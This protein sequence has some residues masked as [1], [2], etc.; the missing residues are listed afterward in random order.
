MEKSATELRNELFEKYFEEKEGMNFSG[1]MKAS[2]PILDVWKKLRPYFEQNVKGFFFHD[3]VEM[4]KEVN[5]RGKNFLIVKF[6]IWKYLIVDLDKKESLQEEEIGNYFDE[7]FFIENFKD[8]KVEK[9][10]NYTDCY[11]FI[12]YL[13]DVSE[14][15]TFYRN[16]KMLF[17]V[18]S[19]IYY[20]IGIENAWTY[21]SVDF[22]SGSV[23]LGFQ[24]ED[25]FLYEQLF[26]NS[27]LEPW[28]MQDAQSKIGKEKMLEMFARIKDIRIP[29][30]SIPED[31][32][33]V[34]SI[35]YEEPSTVQK[36]DSKQKKIGQ[37][38]SG[39]ENK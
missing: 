31:L 10:E 2:Q 20:R 9:R 19:Q 30:S 28:A 15:I 36:G 33:K 18:T 35:F 38:P 39:N 24:T 27:K 37:M 26:L 25:Q 1:L 12:K 17:S 16:H 4:L 3:G 7:T 32:Y 6:R 13:G 34:L 23:H 22:T 8:P 14:L 21:L 11:Y 5:M 29:E